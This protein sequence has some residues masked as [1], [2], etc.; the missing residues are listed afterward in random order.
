[1]RVVLFSFLVAALSAVHAAPELGEA[2]VSCKL[3][4]GHKLVIGCSVGCDKFF[5]D[6]LKAE[7]KARGY[8]VRFVNIGKT[9]TKFE[10]L[11][12]YLIPGGADIQP[13][14]WVDAL[15][16]QS[17][18]QQ[19]HQRY[20]R[21]GKWTD[22]SKA[23]DAFEHKKMAEYFSSP[24]TVDL[25]A[26]GVCY[27]MQMMAVSNGFPMRVDEKEELGIPN[28]YRV[29]DTVWLEADSVLRE[30]VGRHVLRGLEAH[31]QSVDLRFVTPEQ[32]EK[33]RVAGSSN[34]GMIPEVM[35]YVDRPALGVQFH[36]EHSR[37]EVKQAVFGWLLDSAC[38]RHESRVAKK[39]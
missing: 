26:L 10:K 22:A 15:P 36:P 31:H 8:V 14:Y 4:S 24:E 1:M 35:E 33:V 7:A 17:E 32:L 27:G 13:E 18:R 5:K 9:S 6:S 29:E 25:P 11:D 37:I 30:R 39:R 12:A 34:S 16:D 38:L 20:A 3:P 19:A 2:A 23:R 21:L 28:R